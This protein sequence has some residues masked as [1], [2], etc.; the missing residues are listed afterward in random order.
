MS[1]LGAQQGSG[2]VLQR[3]VGVEVS[4]NFVALGFWDFRA[5][6]SGSTLGWLVHVIVFNAKPCHAATHTYTSLLQRGP[7]AKES[8]S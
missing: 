4:S 3:F 1:C 5:E 7:S 2:C 8:L 6:G